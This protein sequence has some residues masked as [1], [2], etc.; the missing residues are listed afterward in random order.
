MR[1]IYKYP[2]QERLGGITV[3]TARIHRLLNILN[4]PGTGNCLWCE[5]DDDADEVKM[6]ILTLGTGVDYDPT[7]LDSEEWEYIGTAI[8]THGYV[9]HY[10]AHFELPDPEWGD[11]VATAK[12]PL[13]REKEKECVCGRC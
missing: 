2:L 11:Y 6:T 13:P 12:A 1:R 4:Q 7:V 8:D 10:Y 9:W 3:V 5:V